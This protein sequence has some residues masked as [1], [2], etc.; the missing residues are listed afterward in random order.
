MSVEA[1]PSQVDDPAGYMRWWRATHPEPYARVRARQKARDR[2]LRR[3]GRIY[4]HDLDR[5]VAEELAKETAS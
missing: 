5:L 1:P 3:L 4:R 2:A